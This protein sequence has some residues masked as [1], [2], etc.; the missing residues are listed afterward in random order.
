M[1]LN[2]TGQIA[3]YQALGDINTN[4]PLLYFIEQNNT[5]YGAVFGEGIWRWRIADYAENQ[6][7]N[8]FNT[9]IDKLTQYLVLKKDA[10]NLRLKLPRKT[11]NLEDVRISAEFYNDN[12]EKVNDAT[13]EFELINGKDISVFD[14]ANNNGE[15]QLNLGK[16]KAGKYSWVA[17]TN[18]N[19]RKYE[20]KGVFVISAVLKEDLDLKAN[21]NLLKQISSQSNGAFYELKQYRCI[22]K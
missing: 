5:K 22:V 15:Y 18:Y 21:H 14:F 3:L 20:K 7:T 10:S 1:E 6:N 4:K 17:K 12:L 8:N 19:G 16:L 2:N 11:N 13:V 9:L